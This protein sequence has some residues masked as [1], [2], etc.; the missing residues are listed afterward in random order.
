MSSDTL[1]IHR[2]K[3]LDCHKLIKILHLF[4]HDSDSLLLMVMDLHQHAL[5]KVL[6]KQQVLVSNLIIGAELL[7][8]KQ[9][10]SFHV[11]FSNEQGLWISSTDFFK[12]TNSTF[13]IFVLSEAVYSTED[14]VQLGK[15][16]IF[17]SLIF[18]LIRFILCLDFVN[19]RV[20]SG[21]ALVR[22]VVQLRTFKI[23]FSGPMTDDHMF[24][25]CSL[26]AVLKLL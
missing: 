21:E 5:I 3:L 9:A 20:D 13:R 1:F 26:L 23:Y 6:S 10:K 15:H 11:V 25:N 8:I 14:I 24:S 22:Q 7:F 2:V 4:Y 18:F 17:L 12:L 16:F 19:Q